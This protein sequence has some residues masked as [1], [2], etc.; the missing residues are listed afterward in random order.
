MW[1]LRRPNPSVAPS[2]IDPDLDPE[3][4]GGRGGARPSVHRA[5]IAVIAAGGVIGAEARYGIAQ[6]IPHRAGEFPWSTLVVNASG[7][8]LIGALMVVLL[9]LTSAH[10]L[11]RPFLAVGVLGGYTTFSAFAV[12]VDNLLRHDEFVGAATYVLAMVVVCA[13]AVWSATVVT[14]LAGRAF[15]GNR[16]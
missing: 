6:V 16:A 12:D 8:L 4:E 14:R 15:V 2:D 13:A 1:S 10:W 9:E 3:E 5:E 11:L 7:C